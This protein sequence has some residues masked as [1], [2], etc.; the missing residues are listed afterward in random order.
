[1]EKRKLLL[2]VLRNESKN[3]PDLSL[4]STNC[5]KKLHYHTHTH[6]HTKQYPLS[7]KGK[8]HG[9]KKINRQSFCG[10]QIPMHWLS[11]NQTWDHGDD[12]T[13]R[14]PL[15]R[16]QSAPLCPRGWQSRGAQGR[17][18]ELKRS[19]NG[20]AFAFPLCFPSTPAPPPFYRQ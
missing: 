8:S 11:E 12:R 5:Q 4:W 14:L 16:E 15:R 3:R 10:F 9:K 20:H 18:R 7:V 2:C 6:T 19:T 1:M 13:R 17:S